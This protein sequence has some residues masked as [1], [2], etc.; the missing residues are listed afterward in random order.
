M[1]LLTPKLSPRSP[2]WASCLIVFFSSWPQS[3]LPLPLQRWPLFPVPVGASCLPPAACPSLTRPPPLHER[4]LCV[5]SSQLCFLVFRGLLLLTTVYEAE[6]GPPRP[7]PAQY[8]PNRHIQTPVDHFCF[9]ITFLP[10]VLFFSL[11]FSGFKL[12]CRVCLSAVC[13][14]I[15]T[16]K[17]W[18]IW[19]L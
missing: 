12:A 11:R 1:E 5:V 10:T 19:Y 4:Q 14:Y 16:L 8:M 18:R 13:V 9:L 15:S 2:C 6:D 3:L 17:V 7:P